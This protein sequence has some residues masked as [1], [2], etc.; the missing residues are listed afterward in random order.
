MNMKN[1]TRKT[2]KI[3]VPL[4][5]SSILLMTSRGCV[6]D[7]YE[8]GLLHGLACGAQFFALLQIVAFFREAFRSRPPYSQLKQ[9][10]HG[11]N[12]TI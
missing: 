5:I 1:G 3:F 6:V 9:Q 7:S 8:M 10:R 4:I 2:L 11:N 12:Q